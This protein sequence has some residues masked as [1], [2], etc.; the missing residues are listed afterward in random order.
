MSEKDW[1]VIAAAVLVLFSLGGLGMMGYGGM[2]GS[3]GWT[4]V[5]VWSVWPI[6]VL[7]GLLFLGALAWL[8]SRGASLGRPEHGA[9]GIL[10]ERLAKGEISVKEYGQ[11]QKVVQDE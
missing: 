5:G 9:G 10:R 11:L 8:F 7:L 1:F 2:M 3:W 6:H 4:G